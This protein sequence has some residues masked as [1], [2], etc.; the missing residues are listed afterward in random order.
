MASDAYNIHATYMGLGISHEHPIENTG[1]FDRI[2]VL[3][4]RIVVELVFEK[5]W[6]N[7][8]SRIASYFVFPV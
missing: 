8:R 2:Y 6:Q 3:I 7:A 4:H 1:N 5:N